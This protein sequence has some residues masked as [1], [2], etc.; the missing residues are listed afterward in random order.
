MIDWLKSLIFRYPLVKLWFKNWSSYGSN[1][2]FQD[3]LNL[4]SKAYPDALNLVQMDNGS[5]HKSLDLKWPDNIIP[6]F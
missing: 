4:F 1:H 3:F 5:F 2:S 6:I